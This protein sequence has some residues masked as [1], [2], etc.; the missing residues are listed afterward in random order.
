MSASLHYEHMKTPIKPLGDKSIKDVTFTMQEQAM[1]GH[2]GTNEPKTIGDHTQIEADISTEFI[3]LDPGA[4]SE[5]DVGKLGFKLSETMGNH[6]VC[7][8]KYCANQYPDFQSADHDL[9][10]TLDMNV[11]L[12]H[13]M[14]T[15]DFRVSLRDAHLKTTMTL[16]IN[17]RVFYLT[18]HQEKAAK[19][20]QSEEPL[21]Q[22]NH[23]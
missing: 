4:T 17:V 9:E 10:G 15:G 13:V 21:K 11:V 7:V 22:E 14:G 5:K 19:L 8:L 18:D 2:N 1:V 12:A 3:F 23:E 16:R 20:D 6:R